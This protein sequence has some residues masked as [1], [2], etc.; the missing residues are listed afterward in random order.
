M[1]PCESEN[2]LRMVEPSIK[3][4]DTNFRNAVSLA[5]LPTSA[6]CHLFFTLVSCSAY[7]STLKMGATCFSETSVDFQRTTRHYIPEY[8]TLHNHRCENFKSYMLTVTLLYA[9]MQY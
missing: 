3:L 6:A 8:R 2:V 5:E 7:S 1:L 9:E 4:Q